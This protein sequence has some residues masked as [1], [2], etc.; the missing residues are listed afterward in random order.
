[1][2]IFQAA[3]FKGINII[4]L[5]KYVSSGT[6]INYKGKKSRSQQKVYFDL[7]EKVTGVRMILGIL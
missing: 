6:M 7:L 3:L 5:V 1:M 2:Q 4:A